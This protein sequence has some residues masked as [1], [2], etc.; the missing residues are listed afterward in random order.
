MIRDGTGFR[1]PSSNKGCVTNLF[2]KYQCKRMYISA[3]F[4]CR[5]A[6]PQVPASPIFSLQIDPL[7]DPVILQNNPIM[8]MFDV[9][10]HYI[11]A[12]KLFETVLLHVVFYRLFLLLIM[13]HYRKV[14]LK[15]NKILAFKISKILVPKIKILNLMMCL[16]IFMITL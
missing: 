2:I 1:L 3:T 12:Y 9:V 11:I 8:I 10:C 5:S 4:V 6:A 15:I 16:V 7:P 13:L 14:L